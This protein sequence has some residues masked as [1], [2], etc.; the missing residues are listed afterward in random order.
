MT[1]AAI[2]KGCGV[3]AQAVAQWEYG[4]AEPNLD[5]LCTLSKLLEIALTELLGGNVEQRG[6]GELSDKLDEVLT[7]IPLARGAI[8]DTE[9]RTVA[10]H[11]G[12]YVVAL[13]AGEKAP[14]VGRVVWPRKF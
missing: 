9:P 2:G 3:S 6:L 12:L 11:S 7:I 10:P 5:T 1:L 4:T 14:I 8:V 13:N